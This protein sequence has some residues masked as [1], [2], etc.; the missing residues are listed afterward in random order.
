MNTILDVEILFF[1]DLEND[2]DE[3]RE[4]MLVK[5]KQ[6]QTWILFFNGRTK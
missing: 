4:F 2:C 3:I 1:V 5:T 6:K